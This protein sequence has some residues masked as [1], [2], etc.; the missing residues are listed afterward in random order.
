[1]REALAAAFRSSCRLLLYTGG[2]PG[3]AAPA[4]HRDLADRRYIRAAAAADDH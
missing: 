3:T 1:M 2:N 4:P